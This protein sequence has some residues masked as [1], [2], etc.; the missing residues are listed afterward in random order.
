MFYLLLLAVTCLP[1]L[2]FAMEQNFT[3][4][5]SKINVKTFLKEQACNKRNAQKNT[6]FYQLAIDCSSFSNWE[7][8]VLLLENYTKNHVGHIPNPFIEHK[9]M[10]PNERIYNTAKEEAIFQLKHTG[11]PVCGVLRDF[12]DEV[13]I[14]FLDFSASQK[15]RDL[16][17]AGAVQKQ[18]ENK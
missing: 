10:I 5:N 15:S 6:F 8:V 9:K 11:N 7:E 18:P 17:I 13:E 2:T 4:K 1:L 3:N 14:M 16:M 12:F